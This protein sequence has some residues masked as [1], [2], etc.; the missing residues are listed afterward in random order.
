MLK[1]GYSRRFA[2]AVAAS[3]GALGSLIPP[4]NLMVIYAL[5][6]EV[7][8]PRMFFAGIVPGIVVTALLLVTAWYIAM[9]NGF[10]G[11]E[12]PSLSA[13]CCG[14]CGMANGPW[15]RR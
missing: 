3:A 11:R 6:A 9:R 15:G 2:G 10:G 7:S 5:V 4:S 8:I 14:P 13:H 12:H 1:E